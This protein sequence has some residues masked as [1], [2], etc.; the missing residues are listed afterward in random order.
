MPCIAIFTPNFGAE[1]S[2]I[3]FQ[4]TNK[5]TNKQNYPTNYNVYI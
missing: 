2:L 5:Q 1:F 3:I 4:Q